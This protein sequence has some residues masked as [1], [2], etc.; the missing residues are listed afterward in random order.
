MTH[1]NSQTPTQ[2]DTNGSSPTPTS[3][4]PANPLFSY[5]AGL[6]SPNAPKAE[7]R[8]VWSIS[9]HTLV[10]FFTATNVNGVTRVPADA[11]GA[12]LRLAHGKDGG[13]KFSKS[14]L[15]DSRAHES[16][17]KEVTIL[18]ANLVADMVGYVQATV[19]TRTEEYKAL[20]ETSQKAAHPLAEKERADLTE[21]IRARAEAE[22]G[23]PSPRRGSQAPKRRARGRG[24][25]G[26]R[27]RR[28]PRARRSVT[29]YHAHLDRMAPRPLP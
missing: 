14:G 20:V 26:G 16:Y 10:P 17:T 7:D 23:R 3:T 6:L 18:R 21:A 5:I 25:A 11:L 29:L 9:L 22:E 4:P 28:S 8:K 13:V 12:P 1:P 27:P 2:H 24:R 15:P 19:E